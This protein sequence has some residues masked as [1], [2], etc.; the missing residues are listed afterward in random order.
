MLVK[1]QSVLKGALLEDELS[2][3]EASEELGE[4]ESEVLASGGDLE[5]QARSASP[6]LHRLV[7]PFRTQFGLWRVRRV[8]RH[9]LDRY[10]LEVVL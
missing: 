6:H 10:G 4:E 8:L 1:F 3:P 5:L 7:L 2:S 9:A